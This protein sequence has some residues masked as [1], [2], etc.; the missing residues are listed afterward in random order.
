MSTTT[1]TLYQHYS[2]AA[3]SQSV[4]SRSSSVGSTSS[5]HS[6][7]TVSS[8]VSRKCV[9]V[10]PTL[11]TTPLTNYSQYLYYSHNQHYSTGTDTTTA[12]M[13]TMSILW[14][15]CGLVPCQPFRLVLTSI[16]VGVFASRTSGHSTSSVGSTRSESSV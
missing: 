6:R 3:S 14:A 10:P 11:P 15:P 1:T 7:G 12:T 2:T 5:G 16:V 8:S 13:A 4:G 9:P